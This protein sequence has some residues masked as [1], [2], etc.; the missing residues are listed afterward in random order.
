MPGKEDDVR[1]DD[2]IKDTSACILLR[3]TGMFDELRTYRRQRQ[4]T[5]EPRLTAYTDEENEPRFRLRYETWQGTEAV[6]G[7]LPEA[8]DIEGLDEQLGLSRDEYVAR[9]LFEGQ[10]VSKGRRRG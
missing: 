7:E 5:A 9:M 8:Y 4:V 2:R 1:Y 6:E 10:T 3:E